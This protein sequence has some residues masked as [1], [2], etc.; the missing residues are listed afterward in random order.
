MSPEAQG[1]PIRLK[2]TCLHLRHKLMYCDDQHATAGM[3]DDSSDTRVYLCAKTQEVL[4]PDDR[5]VHPEDCK[6][7]R[8]CYCHGGPVE[9][10]TQAESRA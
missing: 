10:A 3:V 4:G 8:A 6:P 2:V 9:P 1:R 5:P 7:G